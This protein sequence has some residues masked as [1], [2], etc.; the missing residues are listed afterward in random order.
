MRNEWVRGT[1]SQQAENQR[2]IDEIDAQLQNLWAWYLDALSD[3][4]AGKIGLALL[5]L[6]LVNL[7]A[8]ACLGIFLE[9]LLLWQRFQCWQFNRRVAADNRQMEALAAGISDEE[10]NDLI[11]RYYQLR[12]EEGK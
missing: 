11:D 8:C 1:A 3:L 10:I 6:A 7:A 2:R 12:D 9:A 5:P 4:A